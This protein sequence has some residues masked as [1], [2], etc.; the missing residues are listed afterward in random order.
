MNP[1][2]V[3]V[4]L[5]FMTALFVSSA[6]G[7]TFLPQQLQVRVDRIAFYSQKKDVLNMS[8]TVADERGRAVP[9]LEADDFQVAI[10]GR[11]LGR[12]V[13]AEP[14]VAT[15]RRQAY[16]IL[17]DHRDDA[18]TSLTMVADAVDAFAADMGFRYPGSLIS[19]TDR[20]R[21]V[22][23][24]TIDAHLLGTAALALEPVSG[25][26]KLLEGLLLALQIL[27]PERPTPGEKI[28]RRSVVVLTEGRD[29]DSLF[30]RQA[31][32]DKLAETGAALYVLAYGADRS[33]ELEKLSALCRDS[34]GAYFFIPEPDGLKPALLTVAERLKNPYVLFWNSP[35]ILADGNSHFFEIEVKSGL[36]KGV[37]KLKY[38]APNLH[39]V[40]WI[41][42]LPVALLPILLFL[43]CRGLR[44]FNSRK[45]KGP[46]KGP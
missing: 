42:W 39:Y 8:V 25:R 45:I 32:I 27:E 18:P 14:F 43:A 38:K 13:Q 29:Q 19:Y 23:G 34:G 30:S 40:T 20:P 15:N 26:P 12:P 10:D 1:P 24:P 35:G 22:A 44:R 6:A 2:R 21:I 36:I 33:L 4:L 9:G 3:L 16:S 7:Q 37:E 11:S 31:L 46:E 17:V 28:E 41:N 5:F